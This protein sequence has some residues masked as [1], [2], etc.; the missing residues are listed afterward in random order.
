MPGIGFQQL[1]QHAKAGRVWRVNASISGKLVTRGA[2]AGIPIFAGYLPVAVAFGLLARTH[3]VSLGA[4][5]AWS[6]LVFAGASQ[7]I[8][9]ELLA[10]GTSVLGIIVTTFLVNARHLLMSGAVAERLR[11]GRLRGLVAFGVTDETFAV[12]CTTEQLS[13]EFMLGLEIVAYSGWVT[14]TVL[15]FLGGAVLPEVVQASLGILLYALFVAILVPQTLDRPRTIL[16]VGAAAGAHLA[17]TILA[18]GRP[19][20]RLLVAIVVGSVAGALL[21]D[22]ESSG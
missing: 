3:D 19:G 1:S 13:S 16:I 14:G 18:L 11:G 8:A 10:A 21:P 15:G 4:T 6:V 5:T 9:L 7:F 20:V 2:L 12:A 22:G 17:L